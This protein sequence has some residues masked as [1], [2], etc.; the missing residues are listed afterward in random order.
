MNVKKREK[1][2][3]KLVTQISPKSTLF[4]DIVLAFLIGGTICSMGQL[5]N[6]FISSFGL[7]KEDTGS[8]TSSAMIFIGALL[9]G[10]DIYSTIARYGKAGTL[11][12]I[13]GFANSVVSPAIEYRTEGMILGVGAKMFTI[14]G[15]VLVYGISASVIYGIIYFFLSKGGIL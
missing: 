8:L 10:F 6:F 14:A 13:T 9:T 1:Q 11:V 2:Y 15:P 7:N 5:I 12:P 4:K 3:N